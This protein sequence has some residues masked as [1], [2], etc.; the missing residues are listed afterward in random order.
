MHQAYIKYKPLAKEILVEWYSWFKSVMWHADV[1]TLYVMYFGWK[2]QPTLWNIHQTRWTDDNCRVFLCSVIWREFNRCI[3][4]CTDWTGGVRMYNKNLT[5]SVIYKNLKMQERKIWSVFVSLGC[6]NINDVH[7]S[8][9]IWIHSVFLFIFLHLFSG[10][11]YIPRNRWD[12]ESIL[13]SF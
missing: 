2:R 5:E 12:R 4:T 6:Q 11:C 7:T 9:C 13:F 10:P 3:W 1:M 8:G